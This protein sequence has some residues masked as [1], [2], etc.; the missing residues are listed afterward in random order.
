MRPSF[1]HLTCAETSPRSRSCNVSRSPMLGVSGKITIAPEGEIVQDFQLISQ[2]NA[3]H[4]LNAPSPAATAS[5]AIGAE[6]AWAQEDEA[7]GAEYFDHGVRKDIFEIFKSYGFNYT[8]LRFDS[9]ENFR[10]PRN[11]A[12]GGVSFDHRGFSA[13]WNGVWVPKFRRAATP[14]RRTRRS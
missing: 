11:L 14:T 13:R 4:V 1:T 7:D 2:P 5:L 8:R 9:Y 12:N 6:I 3:L 10:R